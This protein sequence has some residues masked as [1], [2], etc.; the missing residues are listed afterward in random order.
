MMTRVRVH[1]RYAEVARLASLRRHYPHQVQGVVH[2]ALSLR[3]HSPTL[4][5]IAS[6]IS[7][8]RFNTRKRRTSQPSGSPAFFHAKLRLEESKS[9]RERSAQR[10]EIR[11]P[12]LVTRHRSLV[13]SPASRWNGKWR[14]TCRFHLSRP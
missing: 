9:T 6:L 5:L 10:T 4:G 13:T 14:A 8:E 12:K 7:A 1:S 2:F 11:N 3:Q